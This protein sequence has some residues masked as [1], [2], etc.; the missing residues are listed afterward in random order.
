MDDDGFELE[1][2]KGSV[3]QV[4]KAEKM[5]LPGGFLIGAGRRV[6]IIGEKRGEMRFWAREIRSW[7]KS[8]R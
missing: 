3:W 8:E 6:K 1:D 4:E 5:L 7:G 2:F